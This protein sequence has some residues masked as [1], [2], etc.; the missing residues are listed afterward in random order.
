MITNVELDLEIIP[1]SN[2]FMI[3]QKK[4]PRDEQGREV[5]DPNQYMFEITDARLLVKTLGQNF[6]LLIVFY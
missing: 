4:P 6:F 1:Q 3:I 5:A 2:D